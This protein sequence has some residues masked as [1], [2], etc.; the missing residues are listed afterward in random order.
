[1]NQRN[2]PAVCEPLTPEP[3]N[4]LLAWL[5]SVTDR[6]PRSRARPWGL[7]SLIAVTLALG[8]WGFREL[9]LADSLSL[10]QSIYHAAHLYTLEIGPAEGSGDSAVGPNWQIVLAFVLAAML[11]VRALLALAGGVGRRVV[12]R[13]ALAGP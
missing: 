3:P 12:T 10:L 8:T 1:M 2:P 9:P 11:I 7:V 6:R 5:A 13:R 4:H